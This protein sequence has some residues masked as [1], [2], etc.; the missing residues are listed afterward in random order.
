MT[1]PPHMQAALAILD[2]TRRD[3]LQYLRAEEAVVTS[4]KDGTHMA[5]S[6]HYQ[7]LAIDLRTRDFVER[8][9]FLLESQ[10]GHGWDVVVE[11]DHI[12]LERD[13]KKKPLQD[14]TGGSEVTG[15][16]TDAV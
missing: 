8:W 5:T 2:E 7:G 6:L 1:L 11:K 16:R 14:P 3:A 4:G 15:E 12:H 10:L 13:P 9:G